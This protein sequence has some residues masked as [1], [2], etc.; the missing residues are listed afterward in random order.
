MKAQQHSP[1]VW[2]CS[3]MG[4]GVLNILAGSRVRLEASRMPSIRRCEENQNYKLV[5]VTRKTL[6]VGR[7][8]KKCRMIVNLNRA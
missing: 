2:T 7:E 3:Q 8:T 6:Q 4:P 1:E 5:S